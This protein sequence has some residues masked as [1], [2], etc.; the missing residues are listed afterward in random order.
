MNTT[1]R[2]SR[3]EA[4]VRS[5]L[6]LMTLEDRLTPALT[7][8]FDY[9]LDTSGFFSDPTRRSV[10]ETAAANL[11]SRITST[12]AA[13]TPSGANTWRA[14]F[15]HPSTLGEVTL[16]NL[17]IP[18]GTLKIFAGGANLSGS[19]AGQG[20][21]GG[22]WVSGTRTWQQT[23]ST[24]GMSGFAPWGGSLSFDTDQNWYFGS[25]PNTPSGQVDFYS[26][27]S[28][29]LL[30]TLGFGTSDQWEALVQN[31]VFLGSTATAVYGSAP[32]VSPDGAHFGQD[33]HDPTEDDAPVSMMPILT[34]HTRVGVSDLDYAA[35]AD[36]GWRVSGLPGVDPSPSSSSANPSSSTSQPV[37]APSGSTNLP[38]R[39]LTILSGPVNGTVQVYGVG[40]NGQLTPVGT[41]FQPFGDFDGAVRAVAADVNGDGVGDIVLGTGPYGGS[42]IR[43]L[44]G[45]TF[46]DIV[47]AF[48][49]F[50]SSFSGGVF[51]ASGDFNRDGRDDVVITPD[52]GGGS[53]VKIMTLGSGSM[54]NLAD[55]F[56]INDP[57][58]RGGA[59]AAVGDVNGDGT[60]DLI[61]TAGFGGGPRISILDGT[62]ILSGN[63]RNLVPDFFAFEQNLRNG[64]YATLGDVD[65]DG[66]ADLILGAGPG[67][68]PRVLVL[69]GATLIAGGPT[70]ALA[71]PLSDSFVGDAGQRGGVRVMAKDLDNDGKADVVVG[72]G[73]GNAATVLKSVNGRLTSSQTLVPFA[74]LELDGIYVG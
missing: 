29:E 71:K 37:A 67:G 4:S 64:V 40:S 30:H 62:T 53:R 32:P 28:H 35:L 42:R 60:P 52:Q 24:R 68:G 57:A 47:P 23:V 61:V 7:F 16:T 8:Q 27:A 66:K 51:L 36:I 70:V 39:Q 26:V 5:L 58:F 46:Q 13:I 50:E 48:S 54:T 1:T 18:A 17:S 31:G 49:A 55:F 20:G 38:A 44:D 15:D 22:F 56:G 74:G 34:S 12:P 59:R 25:D 3:T 72:S 65:G 63:R 69:S 19:E 2:S 9:S 41:A 14:T 73:T 11:A 6:Q 33:T 43:I 45:K 21:P 10:L